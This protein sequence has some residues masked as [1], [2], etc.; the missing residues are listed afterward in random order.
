MSGHA[1]AAYRT[2]SAAF[3]CS[4]FTDVAA[5]ME[6]TL[7]A[8]LAVDMYISFRVAF[9]VDGTWIVDRPT[10]GADYFRCAA[11][12]CG[13]PKPAASACYASCVSLT[14]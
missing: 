8:V 10:I 13:T 6:W 1:S 9:R 11:L 12:R 2:V 5:C 3:V 14:R 7:M 4:P